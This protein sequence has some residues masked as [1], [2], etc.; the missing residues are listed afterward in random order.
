MFRWYDMTVWSM[1]PSSPGDVTVMSENKLYDEGR[2]KNFA[3]RW[4]GHY[5]LWNV[6]MTWHDSVKYVSFYTRWCYCN[7]RR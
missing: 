3:V 2:P 7:I 1:F 6:E 4:R 5:N